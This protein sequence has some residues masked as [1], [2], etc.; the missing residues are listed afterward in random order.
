VN[1][2]PQETLRILVIAIISGIPS[3]GAAQG[4][5][6][7]IVTAERRETSELETPISIQ[8]FT[9]DD[10]TVDGLR[11]VAD[12]QNATPNLAVNY[13]GFTVQSVNIRG[14]GNMIQ[15][16]NIQPGV[17]MFQDG[18]L[19]AET[20]V[21]QQAFLDVEALEVL[22]GPQGTFVGQSSTGGAVRINSVRPNF[23]GINGFVDVA[24][25]S[26]DNAKISGAVNLPLTDKVST[27]VAFNQERRD[28][29]FENIGNKLLA[30]TD[31]GK[32]PGRVDDLNVRF[33][34]LWQPSDSLS[35]VG[36]MELNTSETDHTAPNQPNPHIYTNPLDPRGFGESRYVRFDRPSGSPT[37]VSASD[38]LLSDP[39]PGTGEP[40]DLAYVLGYN[41]QEI[42]NVNESNRYSL[43]IR[44]TFGNGV[45][46]RSLT[47]YQDNNLR[48]LEDVDATMARGGISRTSVGPNNEYYSQEFN[49]LS[50]T[51]KRYSW[52]VGAS[53]FHRTTPVHFRAD[54]DVPGPAPCGYNG[55]N[56][57]VTPCPVAGVAG[58]P[59]D[60][61]VGN[62]DTLQRHV[63]IFGQF[64]YELSDKLE[65][66]VGARNS[67]DNNTDSQ[68]ISIF[69]L[70]PIPPFAP[71]ASTVV[72]GFPNSALYNCG[73]IPGAYGPG[74]ANPPTK[75][76]DTTPTYKL[77]VNWEPTDNQFIYVFY[78]RGYKSGGQASNFRF[79][80]ELVDDYEFGWKSTILDGR[81]QV[82]AGAF[83]MDYQQMQQ[84]AFLIRPFGALEGSGVE[85][86]NIGDSTI[87]GIELSVNAAFGN[88]G[89]NFGVGYTDS[90]L[91]GIR[92]VDTRFLNQRLNIQGFGF[93]QSCA[94]GQAQYDPSGVPAATVADCY[95]YSNELLSLSGASNLYSPELSYSFSLNYAFPLAGGATIRPRIAFSH[96]DESFSSMF[97]T[98][99]YFLIDSRDLVNMSLSYEKEEWSLQAFC[100]NCTDEGYIASTINSMDTNAVVYGAPRTAGVRFNRKF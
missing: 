42:E 11:T 2:H 43:D 8:V 5:E 60:S 65:L 54:D 81:M 14:I 24:L 93:L 3:L 22:R 89:L 70:G 98:D 15:D 25:G 91:G 87:K 92:T 35:V 45:E 6:E 82:Q 79:E 73:E 48:V 33:S 84:R 37:P 47:G 32:Q 4:L 75:Y 46:F 95:N 68:R 51:D 56:G 57:T 44:R 83:Y 21:L 85:I 88:L 30:D 55:S 20:V 67:F 29:Y 31:I 77:G 17:A 58:L 19:M 1:N 10:L 9:A 72:A 49:I 78:A 18:L 76:K 12:L 71:C 34:I 64:T 80:P 69:S 52:I 96:Q 50:P 61:A 39:P 66:Q 27:R 59:F 94:A 90:D 36:R 23:D 74:L 100:I 62:I 40:S 13:G 63:G 38:A 97:Q 41:T 26:Y 86:Q 16:P 7:I 53:A 99:D 28:S